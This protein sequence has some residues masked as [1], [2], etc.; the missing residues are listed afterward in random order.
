M[1]CEFVLVSFLLDTDCSHHMAR[2]TFV[3]SV[4]SFV[5]LVFAFNALY[6]FVQLPAPC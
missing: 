5:T 3:V 1:S 6:R 2:M 4:T